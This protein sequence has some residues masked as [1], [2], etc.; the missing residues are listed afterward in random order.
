M[1]DVYLPPQK[2]GGYTIIE[3][4]VA[5][6]LGL[7]LLAALSQLFLGSNQT[8]ALQRQLADVQDS[9]RFALWYLREDLMRAGWPETLVAPG[10]VGPTQD[11]EYVDFANNALC[12]GASCTTEGGGAVSDS[13]LVSY[14]APL[15]GGADC[16]GSVIAGGQL[17]QN[18]FYVNNRQLMCQGNGGG[19]AQPLIS[20]VDS[21][22]LLYG[23]DTG[24]EDVS[25]DRIIN[26]YVTAAG[27]PVLNQTQIASV[28]VALL[29]SGEA[30][31]SIANQ[32]RSYQVL[33]QNIQIADNIPRRVF[34]LTIPF[35]NRLVNN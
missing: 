17:I 23:V 7:I 11:V 18:R 6:L 24:V 19:A 1:N 12:G 27:V 2:Q 8:M 4:M 16:N 33:D 5:G 20:N 32:L 3:F 26:Q 29:I 34:T 30:A 22:Q 31:I 21:F 35:Q 25:D 15:A 13:I 9:G 28:R 14:E 10:Q